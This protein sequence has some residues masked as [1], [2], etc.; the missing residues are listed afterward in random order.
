MLPEPARK[1]VSAMG[2]PL[3][4]RGFAGTALV[5]AAVLVFAG[6]AGAPGA[7]AAG[8]TLYVGGAGCS[9]TGPGTQAQPYCTIVEAAAVATAG[10]TV[11]VAAGSYA[12]GIKV[13]NSG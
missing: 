1:G 2:G 3:S 9:D 7:L 4:R 6:V 10:D 5:G 12:G 8:S 13:V 11:L